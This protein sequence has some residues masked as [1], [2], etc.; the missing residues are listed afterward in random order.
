MEKESASENN[1]EEFKELVEKLDAFLDL[2]Y[3]THLIDQDIFQNPVRFNGDVY[4]GKS[5]SQKI[6]FYGKTP[7]V[8][9]TSAITS[10]AYASVGGSAVSSNDTFGGY[11]IGQIVAALKLAGFLA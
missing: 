5:A 11:T 6:G 10:S 2:Y 9:P 8:Q 1:N 3:R 7:V 4:L